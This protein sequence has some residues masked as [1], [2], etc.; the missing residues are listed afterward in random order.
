MLTFVI[1]IFSV[2]KAQ[3]K[4]ARNACFVLVLLIQFLTLLWHF[5]GEPVD[6]LKALF[7]AL[8][9]LL[10]IIVI[11]LTFAA[12]MLN[13]ARDTA[14]ATSLGQAAPSIMLYVTLLPLVLEVYDS[15][16]LPISKIV[17]EGRANGAGTKAI[18][19]A[20]VFLPVTVLL[21]MFK[22]N[23][24]DKLATAANKTAKKLDV[25]RLPRLLRA[26]VNHREGRVNDVE[27]HLICRRD[28]DQ[29]AHELPVSRTSC[30]QG[31]WPAE[32]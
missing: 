25:K 11:S 9:N 31:A 16:A 21:K 18:L 4:G 32:S 13:D 2:V 6:R 12:T 14:A 10:E 30:L 26:R 3:S 5:V 28:R 24:A 29:V 23:G 19:I 1:S 27:E 8:G 22:V 20:I 7:S 17:R 15:L